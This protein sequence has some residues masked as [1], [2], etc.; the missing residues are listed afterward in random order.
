MDV[1]PG[2]LE[3]R[4]SAVCRIALKGGSRRANQCLYT[5][6]DA[7][8]K[9]GT[10]NT[11]LGGVG[12]LR[13]HRRALGWIVNFSGPLRL[14]PECRDLS[15]GC[16]RVP[17]TQASLGVKGSR[18][19]ILV[20]RHGS[21]RRRG[22]AMNRSSGGVPASTLKEG[23]VRQRCLYTYMDP[24]SKKG[25]TNT[26]RGCQPDCRWCR[27]LRSCSRAGRDR[28]T[29]FE[30][31]SVEGARARRSPRVGAAL[32][33][34]RPER[35]AGW[36]TRGCFAAGP[37]TLVPASSPRTLSRAAVASRVWHDWAAGPKLP[38]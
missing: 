13:L 38:P 24:A 14:R 26:D 2:D 28:S 33:P 36:R 35:I 32:A 5:Y 4:S 20:Y 25:A 15:A 18:R 29:F 23:A 21:V 16:L 31:R 37:R 10:T 8:R 34:G 12:D 22:W 7:R 30:F 1:R 19:T 9:G 11:Q 3:H 6:M 17:P 27:G